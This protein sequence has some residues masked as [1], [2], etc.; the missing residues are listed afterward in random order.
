[1]IEVYLIG[2]LITVVFLFK[3][4]MGDGFIEALIAM[5]VV[6]LWPVTL[7]LIMYLLWRES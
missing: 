3:W 6:A 5:I 2:Q 7:P 4:N 1:M